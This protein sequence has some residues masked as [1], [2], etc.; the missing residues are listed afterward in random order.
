SGIGFNLAD[1][2]HLL[3]EDA[4]I[5]LIYHIEVNEWQG[6]NTIQLKVLDIRAAES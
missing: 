4:L 5:D 1:K 2:F 6:R 3:Q